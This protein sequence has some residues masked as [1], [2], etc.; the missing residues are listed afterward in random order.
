M[1]YTFY[2]FDGKIL[3]GGKINPDFGGQ[4]ILLLTNR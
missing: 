2:S 1:E 3:H 4:W